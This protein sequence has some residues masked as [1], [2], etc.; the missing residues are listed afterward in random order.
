MAAFFKWENA[1]TQKIKEIVFDP[2][3]EKLVYVRYNDFN[4]ELQPAPIFK[5]NINYIDLLKNFNLERAY[6]NNFF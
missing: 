5:Q 4:A 3:D 2:S 1:H 6:E